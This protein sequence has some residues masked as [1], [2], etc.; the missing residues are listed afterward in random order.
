MESLTLDVVGPVLVP[1]TGGIRYALVLLDKRSRHM[2]LGFTADIKVSDMEPTI[3]NVRLQISNGTNW[4]WRNLYMDAASQH[5]S[6]E[7]TNLLQGMDVLPFVHPAGQHW[8]NGDVERHIRTVFE[9]AAAH[10]H[11]SN[12]PWQFWPRACQHVQLDYNTTVAKRLQNDPQYN[13]QSP[14][15]ILTGYPFKHQLP[16][17]GQLVYVK[18][19]ELQDRSSSRPNLILQQQRNSMCLPNLQIFFN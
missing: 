6:K 3:R 15:K 7:L 11:A 8:R 16:V 4:T 9:S 14:L 18:A 10:L 1:G 5:R 2:F 12:V 13:D 17:F 19:H